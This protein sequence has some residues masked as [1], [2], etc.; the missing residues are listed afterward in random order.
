MCHSDSRRATCHRVNMGRMGKSVAGMAR[1]YGNNER[2]FK[3]KCQAIVGLQW[4]LSYCFFLSM[5][6][7]TVAMGI[8]GGDVIWGIWG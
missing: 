1:V 5:R 4:F 2:P 8:W 6:R 7:F 3:N